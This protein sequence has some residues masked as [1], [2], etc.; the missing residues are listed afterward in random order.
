MRF[1]L[2]DR[3]ITLNKGNS[4]VGTKSFSLSDEYFRGHFKKQTHVSG[5]FYIEAM[6]QL[7]G[8]LIIYSHDFMLSPFMSLVEKVHFEAALRPDFKAEIHAQL[9][10]TSMTD[11]LG[12]AQMYVDGQQIASLDRII[13]SHSSRVDPLKLRQLFSYYSGWSLPSV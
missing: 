3:I 13:Y 8:W 12:R 2:Y 6:A 1:L 10:S 11:S 4:I 9:V 5:V 7:L